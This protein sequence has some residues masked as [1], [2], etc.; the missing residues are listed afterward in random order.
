MKKLY[1]KL[2]R[3][4]EFLLQRLA[5]YYNKKKLEGPRFRERNKIYLLRR[6]IRTIR[7]SD[8]LDHRKFR[9]FTIKQ[10]IRDT[11][12]ELK[13]FLIIKIYPIFHVSFLELI[14]PDILEKLTPEIY[15]DI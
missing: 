15:L 8:K 12:F 3:D 13:L 1:K 11:S 6:N 5:I 9:S 7:L 14:S 2:S 4:I 10:N